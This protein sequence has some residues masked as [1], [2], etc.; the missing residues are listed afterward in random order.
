MNSRY[1]L[2]C[3]TLGVLMSGFALAETPEDTIANA[4]SAAPASLAADATIVALDGTVLQEGS[5]G[6]TCHPQMPTTGPMCNDAEWEAMI[7]ALMAKQE[8]APGKL[9]VSYM[10]AGEGTAPGV[11]NSDPYATDQTA[12]DW[13]KEGPHLMIILPDRALLEGLSTDPKDPVYV[14]WKDTPYAHIMVRIGDEE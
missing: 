1:V 14:M 12:E 7:G 4:K 3:A 13:V 10:L 2:T 5:N 6:Y 8:Y 11:S 9:G